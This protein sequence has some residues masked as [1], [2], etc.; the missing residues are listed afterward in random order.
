MRLNRIE[1]PAIYKALRT[2]AVNEYNG[3]SYIYSLFKIIHTF[4]LKISFRKIWVRN[5]KPFIQTKKN[6]KNNPSKRHPNISN[7]F[8]SIYLSSN[9]HNLIKREN[10]CL[11]CTEFY[12]TNVDGYY[13][14]FLLS[15]FNQHCYT[16]ILSIICLTGLRI[17]LSFL[18]LFVL[19]KI[20]RTKTEKWLM[21][22]N[23]EKCA[24]IN[25][26]P[27]IYLLDLPN[28]KSLR[29]RKLEK[30]PTLSYKISAKFLSIIS[31]N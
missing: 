11:I 15:I 14:Y 18:I 2:D 9:F 16:L 29:L 24:V 25:Y 8:L 21:E 31:Q 10:F 28:S 1:I 13:T 17:F 12:R 19:L 30:S 22:F 27:K 4:K 6:S 20:I 26:R 3:I 23:E 5:L 7:Y